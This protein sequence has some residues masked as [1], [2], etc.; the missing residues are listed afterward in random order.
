[1][2]KSKTRSKVLAVRFQKLGKVYYFDAGR[3]SDLKVDDYVI[4]STAKGRE[5]AQIAGF[6]D[7]SVKTPKGGWKPI[8][9]R[10]TAQELVGA[11][12]WKQKELEALVKCREKAAELDL[13]D[14]KIVSAMYNY[15]GSRLTFLVTSDG[16]EKTDVKS[17]RSKLGRIYRKPRV[18]V[19]QVGPRDAAKLLS[20]MGACGL[21]AR[22]CARFLSEFSPISIKMAK[23][24]GVSLNPQEITG[25]C[26]RLRCCLIYEFEQYVEARKGMPK[27]KKR[28]ITPMGEGRVI[29][30]NPLKKTVVVQLDD[31]MRQEMLNEDLEPYEELKALQDK[32]AS[33]C[34]KHPN[35]NC[36]CSRK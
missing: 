4:V 27:R 33:P 5:M 26:G 12:L 25:M 32:A 7:S 13:S 1:M 22:C 10:A 14:L 8:E 28:V 11:R 18:E 36:N 3:A 35:G 24:Q 6:V 23:A 17:L 21:E 31:G 34:K 16:E 9:R 30:L 29:D 20:G 2:A 19:R 15:D